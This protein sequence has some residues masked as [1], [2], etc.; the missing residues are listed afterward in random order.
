MRFEQAVRF[1]DSFDRNFRADERFN[2]GI[3]PAVPGHTDDK[4]IRTSDKQRCS[5]AFAG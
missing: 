4:D 1:F 2:K 3:I 5:S